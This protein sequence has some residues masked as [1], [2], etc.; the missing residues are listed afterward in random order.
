MPIGSI[1]VPR[2]GEMLHAW[3]MPGVPAEDRWG[4]VDEQWFA[5]FLADQR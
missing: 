3:L 1:N 2:T 4:H 5:S